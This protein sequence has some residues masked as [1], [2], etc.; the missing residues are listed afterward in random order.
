[1]PRDRKSNAHRTAAQ[2]ALGRPIKP[3]HDVDH[4]N[5]NKADNSPANLRETPHGAHSKL[6]QS[7]GRKSLRRLQKSLTMPTR[8]EKWY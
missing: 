5:E 6:T 3:G 8:G 7:P 4:L 1:M 2:R